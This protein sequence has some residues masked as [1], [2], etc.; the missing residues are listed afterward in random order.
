MRWLICKHC[1]RPFRA[2]RR[3]ARYCSG[4]CRVT[5]HR[6]PPEPKTAE[7]SAARESLRELGRMLDAID[8]KYAPTRLLAYTCEHCGGTFTP[9]RR[10]ARFCSGRCRV[11]A[12]RAKD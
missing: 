9:R 11:A 5:A 2:K 6:Y 8:R 1:G 7:E 10:D 3:D 12:H 4:R